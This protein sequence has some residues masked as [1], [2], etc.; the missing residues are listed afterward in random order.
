[1][2]P[3]LSVQTE[4][5]P[6]MATR[7]RP[8]AASEANVRAWTI[9]EVAELLHISTRTV[10]RLIE[11]GEVEAFHVGRAVRVVAQSVL[12]YREANRLEPTQ[13]DS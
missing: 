12:A 1:M 2:Y 9:A 13:G 4:K 3:I 11:R 7:G 10:E 8:K 5:R 6:D